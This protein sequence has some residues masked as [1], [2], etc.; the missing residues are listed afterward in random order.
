[1]VPVVVVYSICGFDV[2][3]SI[4]HIEKSSLFRNIV[5]CVRSPVEIDVMVYIVNL[6]FILYY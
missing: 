5:N 6:Y 4:L 2:V 1:M 3:F